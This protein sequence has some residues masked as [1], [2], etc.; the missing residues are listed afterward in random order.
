MGSTA[1]HWPDWHLP[2]IAWRAPGAR[3]AR[4]GAGPVLATGE[5][6]LITA[7][8]VAGP[9]VLATALAV[10]HRDSAGWARL[11]WEQVA[12]VW[13]DRDGLVLTGWT[14]DVPARTVLAVR[15]G[16]PLRDFATERVGWTVLVTTRL[17]LTGGRTARVAARRQPGTGRLVWLVAVEPDGAPADGLN[18]ALARLCADLALRP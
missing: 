15:P 11:G 16:G 3:A 7:H 4:A 14:P 9:P 6:V 12:R 1:V 17:T 18:A 5:R 13:A 10:Y 8:T 2:R